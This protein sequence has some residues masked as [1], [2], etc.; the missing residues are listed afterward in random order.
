MKQSKY[1]DTESCIQ[2]IGCLIKNPSLFDETGVFFFVEEDFTTELHKIIFGSLWNMY[3]MGARSFSITRLEEYLNNKP[4]SK[5][6]YD[7]QKGADWFLKAEAAA[8]ITNFKYHYDRVKKMT[9]LRGYED[10]GLDM[11][12]LLDLDELDLIK[13][14]EQR[15]YF[16][17]LT[18]EDIAELIDE[19]ITTIQMRCIDNSIDEASEAGEG[20]FELLSEL[21]ETPDFGAPM[22]GKFV[23][24]ITRGMREKKYYLR[25]APT[26]VGKTRTMIADICYL[27]CD[28]IWEKDKWV[29]TGL[30]LPVVYISTELELMEI[31]TMC[32]A[33]LSDVNEDH[34]LTGKYDFGEKNRVLEAAKILQKAPLFVEEIPDFSLKDIENIIKRNIRTRGVKYIYFDYLHTSMKI[35]EEISRRSGGVRLRED[36]ILFLFSVKLKDIC[37]EFGVFILTSTQ[38]NQD[39]QTS[40]TPDQNLLRG[41]KAVADRIDTG[42]ILLDVTSE[43]I[44]ALSP[45]IKKTGVQPNVKMSI[46]KN[47]RGSY[48]KCCLWMTANK[49]TCRFNGLFVT[50]YDY[51]IIPIEDTNLVVTMDPLKGGE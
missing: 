10:M 40:S 21:E 44:E 31:Q 32:L 42:M 48:N 14:Q 51:N 33:F 45:I 16:D 35:L 26:G 17:S 41:S 4:Q 13:R 46:Y 8:D 9:L 11:S 18:L 15:D 39:W 20:I 3:Q 47:R 37:N 22:Y 28:R 23:N 2:L 27:A 49:A 1:T 6:I 24:T 36:N 34:I 5:A 7:A 19:R 30:S 43:D 29:S 25:S 50:D 38:L 12:W